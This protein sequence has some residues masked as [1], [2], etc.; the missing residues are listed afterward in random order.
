MTKCLSEKQSDLRRL[1][2][3]T[4]EIFTKEEVAHMLEAE[5]LPS[6]GD[7]PKKKS[8][9]KKGIREVKNTPETLHN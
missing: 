1:R 8:V 6:P 7:K 5:S 2:M 9:S 3:P 4:N